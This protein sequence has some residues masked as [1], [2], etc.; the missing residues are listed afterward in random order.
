MAVRNHTEPIAAARRLQT[1]LATNVADGSEVMVSDAKLSTV[2]G[3]SN[4]TLLFDAS[5]AG[6]RERLVARIAP[7]D[8]GIFPKYDLAREHEVMQALA[9]HSRVPVPRVFGREDAPDILG[10]PFLVMECVDGHTLADDPPF[11]VAGWMLEIGSEVR[12]RLNDN[13][14]RVLVDL[15]ASDWQAM[16]LAPQQDSGIDAYIGGLESFFAWATDAPNPVIE[17]GLAWLHNNRPVSESPPCLIWGDARLGNMLFAEDGAVTAALD[18]E[19]AQIGVPEIDLGWWL[20]M[21][22]HHTEGVGAPLPDGLLGPADTVARYEELS[23]RPVPNTA[24]FEVLA[25]VRLSIMMA[26][27][28]VMMAAAGMLPPDSQMALNNPATQ[29]VSAMIGLPELAGASETF[30]GRR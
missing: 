2:S 10:A 7:R 17:A 24:F 27:A 5:W 18:W 25:G 11:T 6:R 23:G 9:V 20:I 19:C 3:M 13:A 15:H 28:A 29:L 14:L 21:L 1:W 22:R 30:I 8:A 16:R 4:E 12:A 26:R